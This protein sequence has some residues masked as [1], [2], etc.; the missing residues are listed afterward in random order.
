M[1]VRE[2]LNE[3]KRGLS[4]KASLGVGL[5]Y[6]AIDDQGFDRKIKI[7]RSM[8]ALLVKEA[9]N[10]ERGKS[11]IRGLDVGIDRSETWPR[12]WEELTAEQKD[13][14]LEKY[15]ED[16]F[17][18]REA[19]DLLLSDEFLMEPAHAA[20]VH[21]FGKDPYKEIGVEPLVGYD[22][23]ELYF[24][25]GRKIIN[26]K[27]ALKINKI[28]AFY[29][30]LGLDENLWN[31]VY[32]NI[33]DD[34]IEFELDS[35]DDEFELS[36]EDLENMKMAERNYE[37]YLNDRLNSIIESYEYGISD[38]GAIS[39]LEKKEFNQNLEII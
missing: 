16:H 29:E 23:D 5:Y 17:I 3:F 24:D 22:P 4:S 37:I 20:L 26:V 11:S 30:F 2:S 6:D 7:K 13:L 33:Y 10:F 9:L 25:I 36:K 21:R 12:S 15:G 34:E 27:N 31:Q 38:E 8:R 32:M 19:M 35:D 1:I 28:D 39:V 18:D 14:A